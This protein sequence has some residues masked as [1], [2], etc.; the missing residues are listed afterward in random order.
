M[1]KWLEAKTIA[2]WII[3]AFV[4]VAILTFSII[5]LVYVNFKKQVESQLQASQ[6]KLD[7]QRKLI[8]TSVIVQERERNR[9]AADLHDSLIGKL[10]ALRLKNQLQYDAR[11][12]DAILE[13]SITEAR[14]ISHDLSPPMLEFMELEDVVVNILS[15]WNSHFSISFYKRILST[16]A[17]SSELKLQITRIIQELLTNTY[18]HAAATGIFIGLKVTTKNVCI[19]LRDNGKGFDAQQGPKGLGL[20]NIELRVMYLNG[21]YKV[22]SGRNGTVSIFVFHL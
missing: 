17:P 18:K 11:Q 4:A 3:I 1:E 10:T 5:K 15:A 13:E 6:L 9:I 8:E 12:S 7:Y 16:A 22:K 14:R 20:K 21:V 19:V 2:T